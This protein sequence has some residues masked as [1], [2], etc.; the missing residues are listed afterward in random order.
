M[1]RHSVPLGIGRQAGVVA[2]VGG[3]DPRDEQVGAP[4]P[5]LRHDGYAAAGRV[6]QVAQVVVPRHGGGRLGRG[7]RRAGQVDVAAALDEHVP[8]TEDCRLEEGEKKID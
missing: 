5:L 2:A 1:H 4:P 3:R 7:G 8:I 6:V